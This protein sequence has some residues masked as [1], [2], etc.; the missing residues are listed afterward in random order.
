MRKSILTL[1][2]ASLAVMALPFAASADPADGK[3]MRHHGHGGH[4]MMMFQGMDKDGDKTISRDEFMAHGADKFKDADTDGS[5]SVS[6]AEFNAFMDRERERRRQMMQERMFKAI[7]KDGNGQIS[8]QE[9]RAFA[10]QKFDRMDR[11]GDGK[12]NQADHKRK[13]ER[14]G[15]KGKKKSGE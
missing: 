7:D 15:D 8:E 2:F 9:M 12:L 11:D 10:E 6:A 5:G 1:G 4:H 3:G 13:G 14:K